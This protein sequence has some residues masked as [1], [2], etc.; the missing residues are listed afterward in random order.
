ML[1]ASALVTLADSLR[2]DYDTADLLQTL[3]D[4]S[5]ALVDAAAAGIILRTDPARS[6]VVASTS[7]RSLEVERDEIATSQGPCFD[8]LQ[9]GTVVSASSTAEIRERWPAV[10]GSFERAGYRSAHA[11]PLRLRDQTIG[12]LNLFRLVDGQLSSSDVHAA[13]ALAEIATIAILQERKI[14]DGAV[15][16]EQL[17][18]AL[19]SRVV[20]EQAKGV[21]SRTHGVDVDEAFRLLRTHARATN[22]KLTEVAAAVVDGS[23]QVPRPGGDRADNEDRSS[24]R[25]G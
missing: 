5:V 13:K 7:V 20:I 15:V 14:S 22:A 8:A 17:E 25:P 19:A 2:E 11:I 1:L 24:G 23:V 10:A 4:Q 6:E 18:H 3:A 21:V 12:T 9:S 16:Q